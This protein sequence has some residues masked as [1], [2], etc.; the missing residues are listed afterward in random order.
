MTEGPI[1]MTTPEMDPSAGGPAEPTPTNASTEHPPVVSAPI[2]PKDAMRALDRASKQGNL[3]GFEQRSDNQFRALVYGEPF[4]RELIGTISAESD[5]C[6][7]DSELRLLLK[8]PVLSVVLVV[9]SIWPGVWLTDSMV[10][11]YFASYPNS[12]WVTAAWYLPLTV[13]PLPW[14]LR[15]MWRK[16]ERVAK[17]ELIKTIEKIERAIGGSSS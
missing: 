5:G 11:T 15:T 17:E 1:T 7:I 13:I 8:M 10:Q 3:P 6:R 2:A 4:D 12:F 14:A 16:S 9:V